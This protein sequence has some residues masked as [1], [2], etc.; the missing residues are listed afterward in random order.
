MMSAWLLAAAI[1]H[2]QL[3]AA[4][5]VPEVEGRAVAS[6]AD[7]VEARRFFKGC[8]HAHSSEHAERSYEKGKGDG[9][10]SPAEIL[11]AYASRGYAFVSVTDHN[12]LTL[13]SGGPTA[14]PG[15][16]LTS[17]Y[18]PKP[19]RPVHVNALCVDREVKG[20][21]GPEKSGAE[22]LAET[23]AL[24]RASGAA[25]VVV[26]H[27]NYAGG[28][29]A[30][31]LD[32]VAGFDAV[33]IRSG[34]KQVGA[35]DAEA[36]LSA[37]MMWDRLLRAGRAVRAV[38]ADDA[39][40]FKGAGDAFPGQAWVQA[41]APSASAADLCAALKAGRFY[42]S[43]GPDLS[44][45]TVGGDSFSLEVSGAWD[46]DRDRV[47]FIADGTVVATRREAAASY[48]LA[49]GERYVRAR[50]TQGGKRAWTQAYLVR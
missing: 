4:A 41:W 9:D 47:E 30:S 7:R 50:V 6:F 19:A 22:V 37:E 38:A 15:I 35:D 34:H 16:E 45:L 48:R 1:A 42:S 33:E 39:H 49:G 8:L 31:D 23:V 11:A 27:P 26:N 36:P 28:L 13:A 12:Q 24:A 46:R 43:S 10:A 29:S 5:Q 2:G 14:L 21:S 44:S 17:R 32:S 25:L 3:Q 40:H 20:V 18:G